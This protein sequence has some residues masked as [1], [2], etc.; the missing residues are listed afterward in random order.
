MTADLTADLTA[1]SCTTF[2]ARKRAFFIEIADYFLKC[3]SNVSLPSLMTKAQSLPRRKQLPFPS[4]T[5][6]Q[7]AFR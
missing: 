6:G 7:M 1:A 5:G 4:F 3:G 2:K